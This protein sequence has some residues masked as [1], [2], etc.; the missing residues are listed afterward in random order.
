LV[1]D[2]FGERLGRTWRE[3]GEERTDWK[4]VITDLMDGRYADPIWIVTFNTG[5]GCCRDVSEE[6]ADE[7]AQRCG[8]DGFEVPPFLERFVEW[9]R[10]GCEPIRHALLGADLSSGPYRFA[11]R[12]PR[13]VMT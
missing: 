6:I 8:M 11:G 5:G 10:L 7:I 12:S 9:H 2:D 13:I 1:L 4:T 3:T